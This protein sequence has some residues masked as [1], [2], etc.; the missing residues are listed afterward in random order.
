MPR[1]KYLQ[2]LVLNTSG[3]CIGSAIALLGIW[4]G[5][6]ARENTTAP[7]STAAYNSSQSAVCA[8]WLFFNIYSVNYL[9]AKF[10]ALSIPVIL[11]G[12]F[13][14]VAFTYGPLFSTI[15][16]GEALIKRE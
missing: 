4:T 15:A 13:T 14:N 6:K 7:G 12:I 2:N 10:S 16:Q 3:I 8:I 1:A 9:R 11:Y 5:I